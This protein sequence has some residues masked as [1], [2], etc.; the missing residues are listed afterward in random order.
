MNTIQ[1]TICAS[2]VLAVT[3]CGGTLRAEEADREFALGVN[4][5]NATL[6]GGDVDGAL[7]QYAEVRTAAPESADLS[8]NMAVAQYRKG[9]VAAAA[10]LFQS[11]ATSENDSL[12]A[13]ARY[14]LGNC[15]YTAGLKLAEQ[16]RPAAIKELE[17]AIDNYRSS[18]EV[19]GNNADARANIELAARLIDKL[20]EEQKQ[21]EQQQNQEQNQEN[22]QN[23]EQQSSNEQQQQ[24]SQQ[25]QG[26]QGKQ[27]QKDPEQQDQQ[28]KQDE[29]KEQATAGRRSAKAGRAAEGFAIGVVTRR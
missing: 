9:D 19:D 22:Q 18:L 29:Q 20:R 16:D 15:N 7:K 14:N 2:L 3:A 28:N 21:Q 4:A 11:A 10:P 8:Y 25:Q 26:S 6:R 23:N 17:S 13:N 27:D 12:A 5:A 1:T 24:N